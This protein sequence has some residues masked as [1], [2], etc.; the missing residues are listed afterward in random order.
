MKVISLTDVKE[1]GRAVKCPKGGFVSYRFLLERDGMGFSVHKTVVPKGDVQHWHYK[2]HLEACYCIAGSGILTNVDTG[3]KHWIFPDHLYALD[4]NDDHT[5][6][7][8]EDVM[9]ISVFNPPVKGAEV[10]REDG[11][12]E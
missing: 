10:H 11:S 5:F 12:Y 6:Q 9:L 4:Q 7:A 3:E 2:N 1:S 8:I